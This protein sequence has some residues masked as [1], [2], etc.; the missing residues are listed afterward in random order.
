MNVTGQAAVVTGGASGLGLATA[1]ALAAAGARVAILDLGEER[2]AA[3]AGDAGV[4]GLVCDVTDEVRVTEVLAEAAAAHGPTRI[5]VN[6]AGVPGPLALLG[7]HGPVD[8]AAYARI[9]EINLFGTI[10]VMTK[11]AAQ[12]REAGA[13]DDDGEAGVI[14]NTSSGTA[15][16]GMPGMGAYAT[17][18]G[19]I[20]SLSLPAAR[21]F[22]R[23]GIRVN[24]IAPGLFETGMAEGVPEPAR[25]AMQRMTIFPPRFGKPD[26][27]A[28]MVVEICRNPAVNGADVRLDGAVRLAPQRT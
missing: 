2:V 12:M 17:S 25:E 13:L 21:E 11:C 10:S 16:D 20:R 3:A 27:F 4:L 23:H 24:S 22:A 6:C 14:V 7:K 26:E 28:S 5:N 19:A 18:K 15:Y 9:I 8:M 1:R